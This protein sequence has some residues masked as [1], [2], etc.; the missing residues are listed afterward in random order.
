MNTLKALVNKSILSENVKK[1]IAI[2]PQQDKPDSYDDL[3]KE[4]GLDMRARL[5]ERTKKPE[6]IAQYE[7]ERLE[8]LE[9]VALVGNYL[10]SRDFCLEPKVYFWGF[11][12]LDEE[13]GT[14][15]NWIEQILARKIE[16]DGGSEHELSSEDPESDEDDGDEEGTDEDSDEDDKTNS[17]KDWERS[18]DD[19]VGTNLEGDEAADHYLKGSSEH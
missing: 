16:N 17:L 11:F 13:K 10:V 7:K 15:R 12:S 18:D 14:K 9:Y 5:S 19:N 6:E 1:D 3:V 4:M 2:A 8:Q